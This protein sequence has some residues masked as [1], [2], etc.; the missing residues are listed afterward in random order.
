[1]NIYVKVDFL[2]VHKVFCFGDGSGMQYKN[3]K[4]FTNLL[5]QEQQDFDLK[6]Q[7]HFSAA[8]HRKNVFDGVGGTIKCF[9]AHASL[10]RPILNQILT[11]LQLFEFANAEIHG[12][13]SFSIST[14]HV[15]HVALFLTQIFEFTQG[16]GHS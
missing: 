4:N 12:V 14:E 9:A 16:Q 6:A 1:M 10:Q 13:T 5:L 7:W 8:S 3:F 15:D 2:H 11:P